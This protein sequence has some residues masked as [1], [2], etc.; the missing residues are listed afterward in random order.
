[1]DKDRIVYDICLAESN[2][3]LEEDSFTLEKNNRYY[4]IGFKEPKN[5]IYLSHFSNKVDN[6]YTLIKITSNNKD[7]LKNHLILDKIYLCNRFYNYVNKEVSTVYI[8]K[9]SVWIRLLD[10]K[11]LYIDKTVVTYDVT[12]IDQLARHVIVGSAQETR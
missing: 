4:V 5:H 12:N 8:E 2:L 9:D 1:M 7:D 3:K 6:H 10:T 11:T